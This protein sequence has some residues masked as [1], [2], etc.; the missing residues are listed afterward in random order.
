MVAGLEDITDGTLRIGDEI[1]NHVDPRDRDIAMV[2]QSYALYPHMT[3]AQE[4]RVAADGP[5]VRRRRGPR[6][7]LDPR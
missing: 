2:F 4:H 5:R 6:R 1:V 7:K 3:V